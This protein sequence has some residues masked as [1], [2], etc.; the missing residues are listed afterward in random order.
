MREFTWHLAFPGWLYYQA[1]L[2][3]IKSRNVDRAQLDQPKKKRALDE[4]VNENTKDAPCSI[5]RTEESFMTGA[6]KVAQMPILHKAGD[7]NQKNTM[8]TR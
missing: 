4:L 1:T 8:K 6:K 5:Y 2:K 3:T 7:G